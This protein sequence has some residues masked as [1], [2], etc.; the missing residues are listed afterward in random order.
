MPTG[1]DRLA[2][3]KLVSDKADWFQL[4]LPVLAFPVVLPEK[5]RVV[6]PITVFLYILLDHW[7]AFAIA[8]RTCQC[9]LK[10][11]MIVLR[12]LSCTSTSSLLGVS[13]LPCAPALS[14]K[15]SRTHDKGA[16]ENYLYKN[17]RLLPQ[18]FLDREP[19]L[20]S[21]IYIL[22][23]SARLLRK[24]AF[25]WWPIRGRHLASGPGPGRS[26]L[27]KKSFFS[28]DLYFLALVIAKSK[29][30]RTGAGVFMPVT[31]R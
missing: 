16:S 13:F 23:P 12:T 18:A 14:I 25:Q 29:F 21:S 30:R 1:K 3:I 28:H 19:V 22:Q 9:A 8:C 6:F 7:P 5:Y 17:G 4:S 10:K 20:Q 31:D 24:R 15:P 27:K 26:I 2:V 11:P